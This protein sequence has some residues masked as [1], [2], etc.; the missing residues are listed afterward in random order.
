MKKFS[1]LVTVLLLS[2]TSFAGVIDGITY[3]RNVKS[4]AGQPVRVAKHCVSFNNDIAIDNAGTFSGGRSIRY[5]YVIV[6]GRIVNAASGKDMGYA[7]NNGGDTILMNSGKY[8]FS[9]R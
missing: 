2:T 4:R 7:V 1:A 6:N 3:C 5:P 8:L 9:K